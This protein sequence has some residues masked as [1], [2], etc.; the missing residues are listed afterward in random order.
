MTFLSNTSSGIRTLNLSNVNYNTLVMKLIKNSIYNL[1][2]NISC[3]V[4]DRTLKI[5]LLFKRSRFATAA[6]LGWPNGWTRTAAS[7][8]RR[9]SPALSRSSIRLRGLYTS[10]TRTSSAQVRVFNYSYP[11]LDCQ[12]FDPMLVCQGLLQCFIIEDLLQ[13]FIIEDLLQCL[14]IKDL[15]Q[16]LIVKWGVINPFNQ[17]LCNFWGAWLFE[18]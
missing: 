13:C 11:M 16:C 7:P 12:G 1:D 4:C 6:C 10:R 8:P 9:S 3:R 17:Y 2:F 15:I 18:V 14:N 5:F